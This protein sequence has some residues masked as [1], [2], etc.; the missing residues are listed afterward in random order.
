MMEERTATER[1]APAAIVKRRSPKLSQSSN[2]GEATPDNAHIPNAD[3]DKPT[4]EDTPLHLRHDH[5]APAA[6]SM[7]CALA[8]PAQC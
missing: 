7:G 6:E 4:R 1:K 5:P 2:K 8:P 3:A